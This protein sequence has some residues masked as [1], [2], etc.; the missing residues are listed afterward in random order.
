M[1]RIVETL[2]ERLDRHSEPYVEGRCRLWLGACTRLGY[3]NVSWKGRMISVHRAA[4]ECERGPIPEGMD[5]L[6]SCDTP[7]CRNIHHLFLGDHQAN[8]DDK[9][10]KGRQSCLKGAENP[11]AKLTEAQVREIRRAPSTTSHRTLAAIYGVHD[12]MIGKVRAW[13]SWRHLAD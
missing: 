7:A 9:V 11:A 5:V 8:M 13:K 1:T 4:W 2:A 12:T 3:G 6:H 10:A